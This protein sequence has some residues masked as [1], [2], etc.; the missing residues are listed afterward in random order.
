MKKALATLTCAA[1]LASCAAIE[2]SAETD[3][4]GYTLPFEVTA[5]TNLAVSDTGE[6]DS[7]TTLNVAWSMNDSMCKWMGEV[8]DNTTYDAVMEKL[9][10]DYGIDELFINT[11]ELNRAIFARSQNDSDFMKISLGKSKQVEPMFE[12]KN[13]KKDEIFYDIGYIIH[14]DDPNCRIEIIMVRYLEFQPPN[15]DFAFS[16]VALKLNRPNI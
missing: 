6:G 7:Q 9:L 8:A 15:G 4:K 5:P 1:I 2:V 11:A 10:K 13:E 14:K 3:L 12:I 16:I